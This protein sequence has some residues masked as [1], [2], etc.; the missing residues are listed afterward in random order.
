MTTFEAFAGEVDDQTRDAETIPLKSGIRN[1]VLSPTKRLV[2]WDDE[3][4][5][6]KHAHTMPTYAYRLSSKKI[7]DTTQKHGE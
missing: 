1:S 3:H 7:R 6:L 4:I 2:C 5:T